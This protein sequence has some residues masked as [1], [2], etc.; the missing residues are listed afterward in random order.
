MKN[1][2]VLSALSILLVSTLAHAGDLP[3]TFRVPRVSFNVNVA[4]EIAEKNCLKAGGTWDPAKKVCTYAIGD[5]S[6]DW[7]WDNVTGFVGATRDA[8]RV[9]KL[10]AV[11]LNRAGVITAR[12]E[13]KKDGSY[14]APANFSASVVLL[15]TPS[16]WTNAVVGQ[17]LTG[18]E[19]LPRF[20]AIDAT[21]KVPNDPQLLSELRASLLSTTG[22]KDVVVAVQNNKLVMKAP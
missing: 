20:Y 4:T 13:V 8:L 5:G 19:T 7:G 16:V 6:T 12:L 22:L 17:K 14:P 21:Q 2:G 18:A 3:V 10:Y 15:A 11:T 9:E 1:L